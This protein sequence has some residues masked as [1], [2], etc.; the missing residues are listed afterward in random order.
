MTTYN[1]T[2]KA[3]VGKS[4]S[5]EHYDRSKEALLR[6]FEERMWFYLACTLMNQN[7]GLDINWTNVDVSIS[8]D[9]E[10]IDPQ[11]FISEFSHML[12][13]NWDGAVERELQRRIRGA[14]IPLQNNLSELS[15]F[16]THVCDEA[17]RKAQDAVKV[18]E[19]ALPR[20]E[21]VDSSFML[22]KGEK[23]PADGLCTCG[24]TI[25]EC[26]ADGGPEW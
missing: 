9:G 23:L 7:R 21:E 25:A 3:A 8:V 19:W 20:F 4:Y 15:E 5:D 1:L 11:D 2:E 16:L 26:D 18:E 13:K 14:V 17:V 12:A 6:V 24:K 10:T 22:T